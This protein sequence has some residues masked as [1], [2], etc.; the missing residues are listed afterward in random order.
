MTPSSDRTYLV[1]AVV[2]GVSLLVLILL[3][4]DLGGAMPILPRFTAVPAPAGAGPTNPRL[5]E[6]FAPATLTQLAP[7]TNLPAP[8]ATTFFQPPPPPPAKKTRKV[9]LTYHGFFETAAG[10][11][12]AFV[13]V[14]GATTL[15]SLGA[16]VVSDL[17][18]SNI[19]RLELT[20]RRA[21]TQEVVI[22]FRG[23]TEVEVPIE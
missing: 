1:A 9:K 15:L 5:K 6:M 20:L 3:A 22:P 14:G 13:N 11:K 17:M 12:R 8:F 2:A 4:R 7:A 16:P 21:V 18:I 23:S 10:E 19:Q